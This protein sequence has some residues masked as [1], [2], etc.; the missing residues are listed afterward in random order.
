MV[1]RFNSYSG[2]IMTLVLLQ[3]AYCSDGNRE[4]IM[5]FSTSIK[6]IIKCYFASISQF[7]NCINVTVLV[8][9]TVLQLDPTSLL[10]RTATHQNGQ[11]DTIFN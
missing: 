8:F 1:R 9:K 11:R 6:L 5:K 2:H 7:R 3:F 4:F 10:Q